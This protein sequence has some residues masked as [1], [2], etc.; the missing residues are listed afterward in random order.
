[1]TSHSK[2]PVEIRLLATAF[3]VFFFY[4]VVIRGEVLH[5]GG[6]LG[7]RG[8]YPLPRVEAGIIA[9]LASCFLLFSIWRESDAFS[10]LKELWFRI[11]FPGRIE[12]LFGSAKDEQKHDT[13]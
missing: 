8:G 9:C 4:K 2:L 6:A 13:R 5:T 10:D 3:V 7:G 11:R 1:M 12:T